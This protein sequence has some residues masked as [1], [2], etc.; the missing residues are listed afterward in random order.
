MSEST[1]TKINAEEFFALP[2]TSQTEELIHGA[3]IVAPPPNPR[4]Q[5]IVLNLVRILLAIQ[6]KRGGQI[7]FAPIA[8][9]LDEDN[10]PEP[11]VVY[12]MPNSRCKKGKQ[13]L[14]G[15]PELLIEVHSPGTA[16]RDKREKFQLYESFGAQE[17]WMIDPS[18]EYVEVWQREGEKFK[19]LG[20]FAPEEHFA[21]KPLG[22]IIDCKGIF[23]TAV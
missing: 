19:L 11:D 5:E 2:E 14:E 18:A 12:L 8:I 1:K 16:R 6:A 13:S 22:E 17:Y 3:L 4:H 9:K 7:Y 15:M 23:L 21:S 20:I 10:V